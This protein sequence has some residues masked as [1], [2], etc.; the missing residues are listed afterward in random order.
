VGVVLGLAV[1]VLPLAAAMPR[2]GLGGAIDRAPGI[3]FA[4]HRQVQLD[5]LSDDRPVPRPY[6]AAL[7]PA[8]VPAVLAP[9]PGSGSIAEDGHHDPAARALSP[10]TPRGPPAP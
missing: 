7:P 3:L 4:R 10:G 1:Y 9:D 2:T 6:A 5:A 8:C